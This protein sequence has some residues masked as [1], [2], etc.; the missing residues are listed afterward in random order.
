MSHLNKAIHN[1]LSLYRIAGF[2]AAVLHFI[3]CLGGPLS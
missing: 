2:R 1:S 3:Y